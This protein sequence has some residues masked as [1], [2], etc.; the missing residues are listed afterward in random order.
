MQ[1]INKNYLE[2]L[3]VWTPVH[4][5]YGT[6]GGIGSLNFE[7]FVS[8]TISYAHD[9]IEEAKCHK[10]AVGC[11]R[12]ACDAWVYFCFRHRLILKRPETKVSYGTR[13]QYVRD[14][15]EGKSLDGLVVASI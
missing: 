4:G 9:A 10:Q 6:V 2:T 1:Y 8:I 3:L 11:P 12:A 14:R 5:P 15:I 13:E 7:L